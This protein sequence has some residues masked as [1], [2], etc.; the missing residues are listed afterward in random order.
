[1]NRENTVIMDILKNQILFSELDDSDI[2]SLALDFE[3]VSLA[4]GTSL[5]TE[6]DPAEYFYIVAKGTLSISVLKGKRRQKYATFT[7]GDYFGQ[8]CLDE[9]IHGDKALAFDDVEYLRLPK[10]RLLSL[11]KQYPRINRSL[12]ITADSRK[13]ARRKLFKWLDEDEAVYMITRKHEFFLYIRMLLPMVFMVGFLYLIGWGTVESNS[14]YMIVGFTVLLISI[15]LSVWLWRD[16]GNDYYAVTS[17]RVLWIEKVI[18]LYDSRQ[19]APLSTI[20]S[21]NVQSF[22]SLRLLI[23]YGT[24]NVKTYTGEIPMKRIRAPEQMV[25]FIN[26]QQK[27]TSDLSKLIDNDVMEVVIGQRLGLIDEKSIQSKKTP[28]PLPKHEVKSTATG[29]IFIDFIKMRYVQGDKITYRKHW[30][31]LLKKIWLQSLVFVGLFILLYYL[32]QTEQINQTTAGI[33]LFVSFL[34]FGISIYQYIDWRNDIYVI[35]VEHIYDIERKPLGREDKKSA[36]LE[37]ILSLEHSRVG[38]LGLMLNYGTVTIN[39]GTEKFQ[40]YGVFNP[41]QVQSEIFARM[42]AQQR[43]TEELEA[44]KDRNRVADWIAIYHKQTEKLNIS[45]S[46]PENL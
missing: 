11:L 12:R 37:N 24:V 42:S 7:V 22:F 14:T 23:D 6:N 46:H 10:T 28:Q 39:V 45:P 38:I 44:V 5:Y 18:L 3:F 17:K 41:A 31:V 20:L 27:R 43:R 40:F 1:M 33:W 25:E 15:G 21:S 4:S 2:S 34:I 13:M 36:S 35:T 9:G 26:G 30:F 8:E 29:N 19:E 16:W 32:Y